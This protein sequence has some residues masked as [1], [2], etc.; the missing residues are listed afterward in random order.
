MLRTDDLETPVFS[1]L[2]ELDLSTVEPSVAGPK[3]P[4]D[5]V[6]LPSVWQSFTSAFAVDEKPA[7]DDVARFDFEGGAADVAGGRA[8]A[9]AVMAR[10]TQRVRTGSVV[11]AAITSCTNTSNPSVMVAAGLLAQH[12]RQRGPPES[13]AVKA[14]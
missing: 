14:L 1:E 6:S 4:Q 5:R 9:A 3:R 7:N 10:P 13:P 8:P 2:L 11:I 12:A